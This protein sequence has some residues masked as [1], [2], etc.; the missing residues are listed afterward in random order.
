MTTIEFLSHLYSLDVQ[1]WID[2]ERLRYRAPQ[3]VMTAS[4]RAG[5]AERKAEIIA[6]LRQVSSGPQRT[7][8]PLRPVAHDRPLP[9]SFSQQRQWFLDQL[10]PHSSAY[11]MPAAMRLVG[12]LD[13]PAL[14]RSLNEIVRRH[15]AL[16]T[17]FVVQDGQPMQLIAPARP[18]P[19]PLIDLCGLSDVEREAAATRLAAAEARAPF[20]LSRGPLLRATLLRLDRHD[21]ILLPTMHHIVADGWSM[22]VLVGELAT[23][24]SAFAAGQPASLPELPIQYADYAV[25][26]REWLQGEV[27]E[28]HLA[29]WRRQ[30]ADLGVLELPTDFVRPPVQSFHGASVPF[31]VA[32]G[33]SG[34]PAQWDPKLGIHVT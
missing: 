12:A 3:G 21:H 8:P 17:M 27:L 28:E 33:T 20:D 24:Y 9:L 14:R 10:D 11:I 1:L 22:S 23:L 34:F 15:E 13:A 16:R 5:L 2:G 29:Y 7:A 26:Q 30:L 6:F 4:L 31:S 18:R 25:W 32:S 19:L